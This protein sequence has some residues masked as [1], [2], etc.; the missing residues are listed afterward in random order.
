MYGWWVR[1]K[2]NRRGMWME[3]EGSRWVFVK[4]TK[5]V[6]KWEIQRVELGIVWEKSK[7]KWRGG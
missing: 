4:G 6:K 5:R 2:G 3:R 1:R 7:E